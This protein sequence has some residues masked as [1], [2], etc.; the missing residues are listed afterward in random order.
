MQLTPLPGACGSN[1]KKMALLVV[2]DGLWFTDRRRV[3]LDVADT[4][5][6]SLGLGPAQ[7]K[8]VHYTSRPYFSRKSCLVCS[9]G[10]S[11]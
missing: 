10:C 11:P 8:A 1:S 5:M 3:I 9:V 2:E 6:R 7:Q 4:V